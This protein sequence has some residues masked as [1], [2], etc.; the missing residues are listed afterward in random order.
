MSG[1][2]RSVSAISWRSIASPSMS[3]GEIFGFLGPNGAGK[4][5]TVRMLTGIIR[6][7]AGSIHVMGHDMARD[8]VSAKQQMGWSQ[9]ANAYLD[10][11]ARQNML[12]AADLYDV[13]APVQRSGYEN[14]LRTRPFRPAGSPGARLLKGMHQ[15]LILGMALLHEPRSSSSMS[16]RAGLT[17][18]HPPDHRHAPAPQ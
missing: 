1:I 17:S 3:G 10:L 5:T 4:T 13:P 9:T 2:S 14:T 18:E 8:P 7:D 11:T 12:L 6:P 15:R 16:P